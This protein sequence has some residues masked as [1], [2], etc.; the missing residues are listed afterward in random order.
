M[1]GKGH[2]RRTLGG[3]GI[4]NAGGRWCEALLLNAAN[5]VVFANACIRVSGVISI[6]LR[7]RNLMIFLSIQNLKVAVL[8]HSPDMQ[9][10][11][12]R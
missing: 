5:G 10:L 6:T 4:L 9:L 1:L 8:Q 11:D 7:T 3:G 12:K 2:R